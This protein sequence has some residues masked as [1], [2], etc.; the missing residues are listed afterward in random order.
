MAAFSVYADI[1]IENNQINTHLNMKKLIKLTESDLHKLV[2]ES[3]KKIVTESMGANGGIDVNDIMSLANIVIKKYGHGNMID[4]SNPEELVQNVQ[5][6]M[7]T[8]GCD[9][10]EALVY[11]SGAKG[12]GWG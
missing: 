9:E 12:G 8:E 11:M 10:Y 5:Q 2:K 6:V 4:T 3:V 7:K 1:Y